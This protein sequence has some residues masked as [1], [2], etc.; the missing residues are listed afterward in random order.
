MAS[1]QPHRGAWRVQVYVGGRRESR[2]CATRK[3]A[4][5]WALEREAE[6][7]GKRLP[8]KSFKDALERYAREVSPLHRGERW[9]I[10]RL[11][12][13]GKERIASR[14]LAGMVA[15]DFAD[16]R[17]HRL[18]EVKPGTVAREMTLLRSVLESARRDWGWIKA[19]PM[20]DVRRPTTPQGRARR[21]SQAEIDAVASAFGV[22]DRLVGD[23]AT[24]RVGLAF[25]LAIETA[26]R[27]GEML[28]LTAADL[29]LDEQYVILPKTKNGDRREVPLTK[30]AVEIL[31]A[32]PEGEGPMFG[33]DAGVRDALWR[34]HRPAHLADLHFHDSRGE[35]V[36]RLSKKLDV[37]Q[38]ARAIGHRD[39]RSLMHYY[40]ESAAEMARRLD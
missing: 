20:Q 39:P 29:R 1:I 37:L 28:A 17:D 3:E 11:N 10:L 32:L 4:A 9:E 31:K 8:D 13:I 19:N 16:W 34:K 24:Q 25:L 22:Y 2:V 12:A 36:W 5:A 26:M 23:T 38:L 6:L 40:R 14:K 35:A 30:R 18:T 21:V 27:S 33:M 7:G 15:A